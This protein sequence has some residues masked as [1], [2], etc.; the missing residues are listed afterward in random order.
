MKKNTNKTY[1]DRVHSWGRISTISALCVL[2]MFPIAVTLYLDVS[3][4]VTAILQGLLKL[5][6]TYW[7]VAVVEVIVYTPMLGAGGTYL[8]FVTG[9]IANLKLPCA[10]NAMEGAKVKANS[11]EGEV[12]STISIATS[13]IVTTIVLAIGIIAFAPFL[14]TFTNSALLKPAFAQV[15]PALFGALGAGY[16]I[17]HWRISFFP[18]IIM[19]IVLIFAPTMGASTLL[20]VGIVA[21]VG[22]ALFMYK[23]GL[24]DKVA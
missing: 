23:K 4:S 13:A 3:P 19:I 24:L 16:F 9:N 10:I 20:F 6:P 12:I 11:E 2:L 5:I 21:S 17:K 14:T 22:G 8:S 18:I 7:T 15:L 1:F